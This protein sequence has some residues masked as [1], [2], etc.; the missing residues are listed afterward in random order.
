MGAMKNAAHLAIL[1]VWAV[2]GLIFSLKMLFTA[3]TLMPVLFFWAWF[4]M[5]SAATSWLVTK[6]SSPL[7]ALAS[8]G[9]VFL[10]LNLVPAVVPFLYLR[11]G[12][13]LLRGLFS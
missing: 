5:F 2:L 12:I 11:L 4:A 7:G 9:A 1:A 3:N 8:H 10:S 13:D 6:F